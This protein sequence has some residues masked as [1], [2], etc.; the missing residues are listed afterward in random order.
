[1]ADKSKPT[2]NQPDL[3][4]D[5]VELV[6]GI[7][8]PTSAMEWS[9]SRAGGPGGQ[10]VNKSST[11]V[12]LSTS[13]ADLRTLLGN[14]WVDRLATQAKHCVT[15]DGRFVL[16]DAQSRSQWTNRQACVARLITLVRQS[17]H[18]RPKRRPT[19]PTR[20]SK[21]RRLD[22]KRRRSRLKQYRRGG[23]E[24]ND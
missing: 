24:L 10:H 19:R 6:D 18:P 20:A 11:A 12:T 2:D 23:H 13:L 15:D 17:R 4:R 8:L 21:K 7:V 3:L 9:F 5:G 14:A 1:M 16:R 22:A